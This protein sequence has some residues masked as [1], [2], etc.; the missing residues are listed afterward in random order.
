MKHTLFKKKNNSKI[1]VEFCPITN[2]KLKSKIEHRVL[3]Q[4]FNLFN[5]LVIDKLLVSLI[6]DHVFLTMY[7]E[8]ETKK[9]TFED[10]FFPLFD[11]S[12]N[13]CKQILN[14]FEIAPIN[15]IKIKFQNTI[16][17]CCRWHLGQCLIQK[18]I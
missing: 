9:K 2:V 1:F 11:F 15:L 5:H 7:A 17:S 12:I 16:V 14:R 18:K 13:F 10:V 6:N 8:F 3:M 4:Y